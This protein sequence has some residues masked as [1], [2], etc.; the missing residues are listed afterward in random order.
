MNTQLSPDFLASAMKVQA[1]KSRPMLE[2]QAA[3]LRIAL[4]GRDVNA[5]QIPPDITCGSKNLAG[6]ATGALI[7]EGLLEVVGRVRSPNP[8]A[9]GRKL[10]SCRIPAGKYNTVRTWF[11]RN[12]LPDQQ[13][14]AQLRLF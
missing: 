14:T 10:D 7:A 9:K 4:T 2:A 11:V 5:T 8:N 6:C 3:L 13:Q 1:F 12:G